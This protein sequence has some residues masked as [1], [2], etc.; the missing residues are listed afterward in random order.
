MTDKQDGAS[1]ERRAV[2]RET[3]IPEGTPPVPESASAVFGQRVAVAGLYVELLAGPGIEWGL[4]GPR[5]TPRL[6]DRHVLNSAV[7]RELIEPGARVADAGSGA[8]LPGIPLAIARPDIHMTLIEPMARRTAFLE[9]ARDQL[10]LANVAVVRGRAEDYQVDSCDAVTARAVAPMEKLAQWTLPM[11]R[12]GGRLLALKG[13][14]VENE[15]PTA[16]RALRSLGA[17]SW[18]IEEVGVGVVDPPTRVA[19]VVRG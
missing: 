10:A 5:E 14:S 18:T 6:W 15:L 19:V 9:M 4:I 3:R 1:R 12:H 13:A 2:S 17:V 7:V 11:L 16:V 8:G